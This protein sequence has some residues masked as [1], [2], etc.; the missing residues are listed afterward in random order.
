MEFRRASLSFFSKTADVQGPWP[1][2]PLGPLVQGPWGP[3]DPWSKAPGAPEPLVQGPW[4]PWDPY[5]ICLIY[6]D[7]YMYMAVSILF[8]CLKQGARGT[9]ALF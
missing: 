1:L 9:P 3:W 2:G 8:V 5:L 6:I 7:I 4:G